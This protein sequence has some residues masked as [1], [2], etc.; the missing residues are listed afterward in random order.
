MTYGGYSF[1]PVPLLTLSKNHIKSEA[2]VQIGALHNATLNGSLVATGAG[3]LETM[4]TFMHELRTA[5]QADGKL[6]SVQCDGSTVIECNPR[7]TDINFGESPDNWTR[8]IPFTIA[9]NYDT[10][11]VGIGLAGSGEDFASGLVPPF[12]DSATETWSMEFI[13]ENAAY[14]WDTGGGSLDAG[15]YTLSVSHSVAA[16]GRRHYDQD[17]A[18]SRQAWEEAKAYVTPLLGI[19]N[20]IVAGEGVLNLE[21]VDMTPYNHMRTNEV[22][23][24][25]GNFSVTETWILVNSGSTIATNALEDFTATVRTSL[26]SD[27]TTVGIDGTIQGLETVSFGTTTG[28]YSISEFKYDSAS[29]YWDIVKT[30]LL[31]RVNFVGDTIASRNFNPTA[32]NTSVGHNPT[33]GVI[34]YS[35][36]YD[37]RPCNFVPNSL[38]ESIVIAD[39]NPTDVFAEL[40]VLGRA[41]GP[42]LQEIST[43]TSFKRS[44]SI[45]LIMPIAAANCASYSNISVLV[46]AAPSGEVNNLLCALEVDLTGAYSQVFKSQDSASWDLKAGKYSRQVEWTMGDCSGAIDTSFC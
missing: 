1:S 12:I 17:G 18:V 41:V 9:L 43:V 36:E 26:E 45:D 28:D 4:T 23:E 34:S 31:G 5:F 10:E 14:Q 24:L 30:R 3:G 8:R 35:Y 19:D 22:D 33:K 46:D 25:G 21:I 29:T 38:F 39:D 11:P 2:G 42:I 15:P 32:L 6:F 27:I 7:I 44:V 20:V 40:T 37:D 13:E 16:K